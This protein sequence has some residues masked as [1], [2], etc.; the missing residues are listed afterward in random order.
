MSH[1]SNSKSA[2]YARRSTAKAIGAAIAVIICVAPT[3]RVAHAQSGTVS[4][5]L[6]ARIKQYIDTWNSHDAADLAEYFTADA[7][8]IM[9][10]GPLL[11]GR[12]AIQSWWRDYFAVPE[13][14]RRLAIE[15]KAIRPLTVEV[16]LVNEQTTTG[17]R[18]ARVPELPARKARGTWVLLRQDGDWLITALRGMPMPQDRINRGGG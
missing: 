1:G 2:P 3:V 15:I 17:G 18:T 9:G 13:P 7:D 12:K 4:E 16:V 5:E 8:M 11:D 14:E 10:N 6:N